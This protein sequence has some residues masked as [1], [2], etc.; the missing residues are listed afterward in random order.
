MPGPTW[1]SHRL[2][3]SLAIVAPSITSRGWTRL[4]EHSYARRYRSYDLT[5]GLVVG[6][7]GLLVV[8]SRASTEEARELLADL[9]EVSSLPVVGVVNTHQHV[10]HTLGNAGFEDVP[11][12]GH[13]SLLETLDEHLAGVRGQ[14]RA[15]GADGPRDRAMLESPT[16]LPDV[17]FSS[18]WSTDLGGCLVELMHPGPA[19]TAGDVVVKV[20]PDRVAFAGDLVE[21]SGPPSYG[22]DAHPLEWG[23]AL[24]LLVGVCEPDATVV[25]GHGDAVDRDFVQ[26]QRQTIL[27]VA[28]QIRA[29]SASGMPVEEALRQDWPLDPSLLEQAVR[30]GYEALD[31]T[32]A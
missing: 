10:D 1:H 2:S 29:C 3:A 19:H 24:D 22:D 7:D 6:T 9:R 18:A 4:G 28:N 11:V 16:R 17:T 12:I 13:E 25:P 5:V 20:V 21:Q 14:L 8:D 32:P 31:G 30:R 23:Q 26:D 27:E 15:D